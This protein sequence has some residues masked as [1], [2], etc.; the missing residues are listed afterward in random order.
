MRTLPK[1]LPCP[2]CGAEPVIRPINPEREGNAW[3]AV[4]CLNPRCQANPHVRDDAGLK[5]E[6]GSDVYKEIAIRR[7]NRRRG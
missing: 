7:W 6:C 5:A 1:P 3:G 2:F 4:E